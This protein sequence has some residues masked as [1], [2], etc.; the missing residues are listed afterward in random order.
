MGPS[1]RPVDLGIYGPDY[2]T[3]AVATSASTLALDAL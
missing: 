3:Q 2:S 1:A